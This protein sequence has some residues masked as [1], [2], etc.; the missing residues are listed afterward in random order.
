MEPNE[1]QSETRTSAV[2][3]K[4]DLFR[5]LS[6]PYSNFYGIPPQQ[7]ESHHHDHHN[8]SSS[9]SL[10]LFIYLLPFNP[11]GRTTW[12]YGYHLFSS[13][14][15][16]S[17]II[18]SQFTVR[19]WRKNDHRI[20]HYSKMMMRSPKKIIIFIVMTLWS[21][22]LLFLTVLLLGEMMN[23]YFHPFR[24]KLISFLM[25]YL[26]KMINSS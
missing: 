4:S 26:V 2:W 10:F 20:S 15:W 3:F 25:Q 23:R 13:S 6:P 18:V 11:F 5:C 22:L 8:Y 1:V 16:C 7:N 17:V 14:W 19:A 12:R 9:L 21:G 24:A